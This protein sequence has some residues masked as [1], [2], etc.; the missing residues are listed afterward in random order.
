MYKKFF[1]IIVAL[2][3]SSSIKACDPQDHSLESNFS[4]PMINML[5]SSDSS[6]LWQKKIV[7]LSKA[8]EIVEEWRLEG[9]KIGFT[10]GCYDLL[11]LGHV[12]GLHQAKAQCDYLV[13]GMNSD[14]SV[15]Q[16]KG[17]Q[18]PIQSQE[19]RGAI[20]ASLSCID[21]VIIFDELTPINLITTI[22][23]DILIKGADYTV[24][25]VVGHEHVESYGGKVFLV[26]LIPGCSTTNTIKKILE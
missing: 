25:K 6:Q 14:N 12:Q 21:L 13:L 17:P 8:T 9:K 1:L 22:S 24:D 2:C 26:D 11:H 20:L 7:T 16:I 3:Y 4:K 15:K 19:T 23:P 18:R 10:N 5:T